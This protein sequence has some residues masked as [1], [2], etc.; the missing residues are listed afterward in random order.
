MSTWPDVLTDH[1]LELTAT[2]DRAHDPGQGA[3]DIPVGG[4]AVGQ[5][6]AQAGGAV[7][8]RADVGRPA[9]AGDDA[10]GEIVGTHHGAGTSRWRSRL[11]CTIRYSSSSSGRSSP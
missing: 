9:D 2:L 6:Q 8:D 10:R 11:T 4:G 5:Y 1:D 3:H 7:A